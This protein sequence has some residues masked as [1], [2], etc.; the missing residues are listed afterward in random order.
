MDFVSENDILSL[1]LKI[2]YITRM[3]ELE[4]EMVPVVQAMKVIIDKTEAKKLDD[5]PLESYDEYSKCLD[6]LVVI[7]SEFAELE[8]KLGLYKAVDTVVTLEMTRSQKE[9][10]FKHKA[11]V[12]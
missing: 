2:K 3:D 9:S 4:R 1:E 8:Q 6:E 10:L 12:H 7:F 11:T 5:L